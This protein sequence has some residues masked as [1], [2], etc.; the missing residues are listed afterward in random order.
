MLLG[1]LLRFWDSCFPLSIYLP[2]WLLFSWRGSCSPFL[3][4]Y[5]FG[6]RV[7]QF[8]P[9]FAFEARV[10]CWVYSSP[11]ELVSSNR[12]GLVFS[13]SG[14]LPLPLLGARVPLSW[15]LGRSLFFCFCMR[16]LLALLLRLRFIIRLSLSLDTHGR[17]CFSV[18]AFDGSPRFQ[19]NESSSRQFDFTSVPHLSL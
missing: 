1:F 4:A 10:P 2:I 19:F 11:M 17:F 6:T 7:S 12:F 13:C 9:F 16:N 18:D 15:I 14:F 8:V 5:A 3:L